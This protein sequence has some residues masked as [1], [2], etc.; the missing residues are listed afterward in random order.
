MIKKNEAGDSQSFV[1]FGKEV[2]KQ[3]ETTEAKPLG[4]FMRS[5]SPA[6]VTFTPSAKKSKLKALYM[7]DTE[8]DWTPFPEKS[9]VGTA[10]QD[11]TNRINEG[12]YV[13]NV[14]M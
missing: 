1:T 12:R 3:I 11:E 4:R 13:N 2:F 7:D 5:L 8:S 10:T 9:S 6:H 14:Y